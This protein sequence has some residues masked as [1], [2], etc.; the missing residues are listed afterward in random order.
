MELQLFQQLVGV[1]DSHLNGVLMENQRG[2]WLLFRQLEHKNTQKRKQHFYMDMMQCWNGY[3]QKQFYFTEMSRKNVRE[4]LC[5]FLRFMKNLKD[6][7][8]LLKE[9]HL[10]RGG[11]KNDFFQGTLD[12]VN[13]QLFD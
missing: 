3:N 6:I 11:G 7:F 9:R 4:I 13:E 2:A 8:L 12:T 5:T 10:V 1:I